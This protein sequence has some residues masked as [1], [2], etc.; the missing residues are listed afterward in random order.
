MAKVKVGVIGVGQM[1]DHHVRTYSTLKEA[2]LIGLF[3]ADLSRANEVS[4]K[5][6][7]PAFSSI[8][9][10]LKEV[11]ALSIVCPTSKHYETALACLNKHKH[12]LVE[13]P[14][15]STSQEAREIASLAGNKK[16]VL[17]V[18]MIERFNP[19][20]KKASSLLKHETILGMDFKR[21]SPFPSRISDASVVLD[22]MLHDIDLALSLASS[23][24][25]S[26]KAF[27]N[28]IRTEKLDEA[29]TTLYFKDGL[30]AKL[31][32]SRVKNEKKRL[33][34]ITT[35]KALYEIDLLNKR[36]HK[37][38][39][40][41][42]SDKIE[43]ELEPEDQLTSELK[44]FLLSIDRGRAPKVPGEEGVIPIEIVEE[45]ERLSC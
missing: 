30:I 10:L 44:D 38:T 5:Y 40:E 45:V 21:Y 14:L 37:R 8:D 36:L 1:G 11:G 39:F 42:L 34:V 35:D 7:C 43:I 17:A 13:K 4:V 25:S 31:E 41:A 28:K 15:A 6:N 29:T 20:F 33:A 23:G 2:K 3:D 24:V 9:A 27:G 16:L 22:M 26:V 12:L 32:A 18:G 19:A